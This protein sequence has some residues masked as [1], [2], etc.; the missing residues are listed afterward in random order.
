MCGLRII[1]L[2][3]LHQV[4]S[5]PAQCVRE[6]PEDSYVNIGYCCTL[7]IAES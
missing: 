7:N 4:N 1:S 3:G 6:W 2:P 5:V